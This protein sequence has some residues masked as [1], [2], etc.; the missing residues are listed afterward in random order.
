M[1]FFLRL[2]W[3]HMGLGFPVILPFTSL[4]SGPLPLA[5]FFGALELSQGLLYLLSVLLDP[6]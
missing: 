4:L 3:T 6:Q 2:A 5:T 1:G